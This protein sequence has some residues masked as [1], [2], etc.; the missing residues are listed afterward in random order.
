[1]FST[2]DLTGRTSSGTAA[3]SA[4]PQP[5]APVRASTPSGQTGSST[6]A[7][8]PAYHGIQPRRLPQKRA[9]ERSCILCHR[10]KVKCD[11]TVPC[12]NCVRSGVLCCYPSSKRAPRQPKTTIADIASR[13]VQLERTIVAVAG[14]DAAGDVNGGYE[15]DTVPASGTADVSGS[16]AGWPSGILSSNSSHSMAQAQQSTPRGVPSSLSSIL[17]GEH[18]NDHQRNTTVHSGDGSDDTASLHGY[19]QS[20]T[21]SESGAAAQEILLRNTYA[22]RYINEV[23]LSRV[24]EEEEEIRSALASPKESEAENSFDNEASETSAPAVTLFGTLTNSRYIPQSPSMRNSNSKLHP[25]KRHAMQLWNTYLQIVE[26][27]SKVLHVPTAQISFFTAIHAPEKADPAFESLLFSIYYATVTAYLPDDYRAVFGEDKAVGLDRYRAGME[28]AL[29]QARFLESP[30]LPTLQ[31]LTLFLRTSRAHSPGQSIWIVYGMVLRLAQSIGLHRDGSNFKLSPFECEIR[32]RIWGNMIK[33]DDRSAEDHGID[34][35]LPDVDTDIQEALNINDSEIYPEIKE[36]P[37]PQM[38]WTEMTAAVCIRRLS[39]TVA[40]VVR[41]LTEMK[42]AQLPSDNRS[43]R[44]TFLSPDLPLTEARRVAIMAERNQ[45]V[46]DLL[47]QFNMMVPV[48]RA[49]YKAVRLIQLKSDF[50][51]RLQ[52]ATILA[53]AD[54]NND[55]TTADDGSSV[56]VI[57]TEENLSLACEVIE[58]NFDIMED[59]L[60][61]DFRWTAEI[62]P[63][64][65]VLLYVL[66]HLCV[67]PACNSNPSLRDRAWAVADGMYAMEDSRQR[68]QNVRVRNSKW[69]MLMALRDKAIK[70]RT[71]MEAEK[72]SAP[73]MQMAMN[74]E[75]D[76]DGGQD[77]HMD[78]GQTVA[79][80]SAFPL[81][82]VT[83][84]DRAGASMFDHNRLAAG[85]DP[86]LAT[87]THILAS[88]APSA[89]PNV[90][91]AAFHQANVVDRDMTSLL[92]GESTL[93]MGMDM[94]WMRGFLNWNA[95]ADDFRMRTYDA[96]AWEGAGRM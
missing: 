61:Q 26:P 43:A 79:P 84:I 93:G 44:W 11:K 29:V 67:Q 57:A 75:R 18:R 24:L 22:S 16:H 51:T 1:M 47:K 21:Q 30:S 10:R 45:Y 83:N 19:T 38:Q 7:T 85:Y 80:A 42:A 13:L 56:P 78:D 92:G 46:D 14:G 86:S 3:S 63:Q 81:P 94:E 33:Q 82:N 31:A 77:V 54:G 41:L 60:I 34:V 71:A 58:L 40:H 23:L 62:Y 4:S 27:M 65:H 52:L 70:V 68:R 8:S 95:V 17:A 37:K 20:E 6:A 15:S 74:G 2:S 5:A 55:T 35:G 9:V 12:A 76:R 87:T 28:R 89:D 72:S 48:Q 69:T 73:Q 25:P 90:S 59:E 96:G 50:I 88:G 64:Y 36:L 91:S 66:W 32:R 53:R 39:M 49:S